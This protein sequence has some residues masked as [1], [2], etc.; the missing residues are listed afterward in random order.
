M[1]R[2][3]VEVRQL[4]AEQRKKGL[5]LLDKAKAEDRALTA[6]EIAEADGFLAEIDKLEIEER[7]IEKFEKFGKREP[8]R[9]PDGLNSEER[10][11]SKFSIGKVISAVLSNRS[12]D[13]L[14]R[15]L[16]DDSIMKAASQG[17]GAV[18]QHYISKEILDVLQ[19]SKTKAQAEMRAF[20]TGAPTLGGNTVQTDKVGFF[21]VLRA[22][23]VLDKVGA[24]WLTGLSNNV[25]YT[26]FSK[27][28]T[29]GSLAEQA[30]A[31]DS[32]PNTVI[33][34]MSPKRVGGKMVISKQ[35]LMQ[36]P[37]L[38]GEILTSLQAA[39]YPY[40]EQ[41][42]LMGSG[43]GSTLLGIAAN[44]TAATFVGGVNGANP[45]IAFI[46][47]MKKAIKNGN[48]DQAKMFWLINPNT[49]AA[50]QSTPIDGGSGAMIIPYGNYFMGVDGFISNIPYLVT[51]NITN[52]L[53]KGTA[54]NTCSAAF[55]GDFSNTVIGQY[56]GLDLVVDVT[57]LAE[58]AETKIVAN[59]WW[60]TTITR[61]GTV[62]KTLDLITG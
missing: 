25:D 4:I 22:N 30:A 56:G 3:L 35:L 2:T 21:D 57:T 55:V 61:A 16:V 10:E 36:S 23:R 54:V 33:R 13:G 1:K 32:D 9:K 27:G 29:F 41:M 49:E 18:G 45:S 53:T 48:V 46:Q 43:T 58:T 28:W 50:L 6:A 8:V 52:N 14:E 12:V 37:E 40:I 42:V 19:R 17:L 60:D 7:N 15:E 44:P 24:N 39:L 47:N 62:M 34:S 59:T 51:S 38:E 26:G 20:S 11:I 5:D 31:A